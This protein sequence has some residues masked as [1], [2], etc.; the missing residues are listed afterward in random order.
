MSLVYRQGTAY[1]SPSGS[2]DMKDKRRAVRARVAEV[3][4]WRAEMERDNGS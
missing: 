4:A 3:E 1:T 2:R